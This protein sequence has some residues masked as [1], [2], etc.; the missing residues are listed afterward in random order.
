MSDTLLI[1]GAGGFA[2]RHFVEAAIASRFEIVPTSRRGDATHASCDLLDPASIAKVVQS[3]APTAIVNLAGAAS[4]AKSFRD[5]SRAFQVNCVG[6]LN[7][8]DAVAH[9]AAESHVLCVSSGDVYGDVDER[10]L[11]AREPYPLRPL[12]PYATS[13]AAM[14]LICDQYARTAGLRIAIVRAFNHTGP[15]QSP[16]FAASSFARQIAFA[17]RAGAAAVTLKTGNLDLVR[18]FS[19][20]R[21]IVRAYLQIAEAELT[22]VFNACSA[23]GTALISLVDSLRAATG[24]SVHVQ[25]DQERLR[26]GEVPVL[27]GSGE[28]LQEQIGWS[29]EIPISRTLADLLGWWRERTEP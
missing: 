15:G 2:G 26:P 17:E 22:G 7:L 12:S 14:E 5:P 20:V 24:L 13:K 9:H 19:D 6:V 25:I 18:D 3:A 4:A 21:D 1:L 11:P 16:A 29:A 8:L 23:R 10:E 28:R 27:Y